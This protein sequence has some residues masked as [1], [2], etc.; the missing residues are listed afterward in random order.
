MVSVLNESQFCFLATSLNSKYFSSGDRS[1]PRICG[2]GI[3]GQA[4]VFPMRTDLPRPVLFHILYTISQYPQIFH[5]ATTQASQSSTR[6][7]A[8]RA[9]FKR[10]QRIQYDQ[11]SGTH[12][13]MVDDICFL[14]LQL[15]RAMLLFWIAKQA[16]RKDG[17]FVHLSYSVI[18]T[19]VS[20]T[21]NLPLVVFFWFPERLVAYH[22]VH[23]HF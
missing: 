5:I 12:A 20:V 15:Q 23:I 4:R 17:S 3:Q 21:W 19:Q 2:Q 9:S 10:E 1:R 7:R 13:C 16:F 8:S 22:F 11:K 14:S 6:S 18:L